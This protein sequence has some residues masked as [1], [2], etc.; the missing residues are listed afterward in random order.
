MTGS[1]N[2]CK[3]HNLYQLHILQHTSAE[4]YSGQYNQISA[5][6]FKILATLGAVVFDEG[7][8]QNTF[9]IDLL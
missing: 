5:D 2:S 1:R 6:H 7:Y 9:P 3:A 8:P 4:N